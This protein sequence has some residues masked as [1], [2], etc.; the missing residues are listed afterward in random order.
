MADEEYAEI[1][2]WQE[3]LRDH[4]LFHYL[5]YSPAEAERKKNVMCEIRGDLFVWSSRDS[6]LLTTNLKRMVA[7]PTKDPI[8]Q[9]RHFITLFIASI[10][11]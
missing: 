8:Y 2:N 4:P 6:V 11:I 3:L 5:Q 10:L 7:Y 9:V 1:E